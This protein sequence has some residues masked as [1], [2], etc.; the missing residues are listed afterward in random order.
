[1]NWLVACLVIVT[2]IVIYFPI[3]YIR[4][5]NRV[6]NVLRDIEVNTRLAAGSA[7]MQRVQREVDATQSPRESKGLRAG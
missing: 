4:K 6:L 5:M 7:T 3:V 2:G 1:M